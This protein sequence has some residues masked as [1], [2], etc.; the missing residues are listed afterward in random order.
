[1][2]T[3]ESLVPMGTL[4]DEPDRPHALAILPIGSYEQHGRHLPFAT[5]TVVACVIARELLAV[6]PAQ[7]LPPL[8]I[9]CSQE[10]A[11]WPGTVSISAITL[12]AV[13]R[14]IAADLQR[15]G[16]RGLVL[17]NGHG[18]NY[19]LGNVVQ[20]SAMPMALFPDL[21][22]WATAHAAAGLETPF[23][24]DMHAG[25]LETSILLATHPELVRPG[26]AD[27]LADDRRRMLTVG[28]QPLA[29]EGVVGRPS[30]GSADKG[31]AVLDSLRESFADYLP[32]LLGRQG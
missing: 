18:G 9:S 30:L 12:A 17:V 29:P 21:Q 11:G 1:M 14:D 22:D 25:E 5:D 32:D 8:T 4:A 27:H 16:A 3:T 28:L 7:L 19:V 24:S 13:V 20:E 23:E 6:Q 31:R 15:S 2:P 10:H 26:A